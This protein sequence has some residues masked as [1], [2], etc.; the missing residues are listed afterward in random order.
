VKFR[1]F[2]DVLPCSQVDD[3]RFRRAYCFH[4]QDGGSTHLETSVNINLT[5][6]Q[7]ISED[8]KQHTRRRENLKSHKPLLC[9]I[10]SST[11]TTPSCLSGKHSKE[12]FWNCSVFQ[13]CH[14]ISLRTHP[15]FCQP[16]TSLRL[17]QS[18]VSDYRLDDWGSIP[19]RC[20][21]L[22][23]S[24]CVQ[25]SSEALPA[26]Y[27]MGT[28]GGFLLQGLNWGTGVTL[29]T[30]PNLCRG[31]EWVGPIHPHPLDACVG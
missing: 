8:S 15:F 7:Y 19:S 2:W 5:T 21:G 26:S 17:P 6:R 12:H 9:L 14:P 22:S 4:H 27:P 13:W 16:Y 29:T 28:G 1:V 20:K 3:K 25:T 31:Q 10:T 11:V 24:L 23:S 30:H 18:I